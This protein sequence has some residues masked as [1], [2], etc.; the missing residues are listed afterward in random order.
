[1]F[2]LTNYIDIIGF[3]LYNF[4]HWIIC[5]YPNDSVAECL[6]HARIAFKLGIITSPVGCQ[7]VTYA[8]M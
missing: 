4:K 6:E 8:S 2:S 3:Y 5:K 1:M 7:D